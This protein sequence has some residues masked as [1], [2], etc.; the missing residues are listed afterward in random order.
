MINIGPN[1]RGVLEAALSILVF[2]AVV[3]S[4]GRR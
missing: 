3:W 1:L 2:L 4:R